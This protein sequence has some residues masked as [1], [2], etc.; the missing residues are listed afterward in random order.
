MSARNERDSPNV[1]RHAEEDRA[2]A[3]ESN[4]RLQLKQSLAAMSY[5]EQVTAIQPTLPPLAMSVP[6][7]VSGQVQMSEAGGSETAHAAGVAGT[8]GTTQAKMSS[9]PVRCPSAVQMA[10][11]T[12]DGATASDVQQ[13]DLGDCYLIAAMGAV[14]H[15]IGGL[16]DEIVTETG[17]TTFSVRLF[18]P[19]TGAETLYAVDIE[20]LPTRFDGTLEFAKSTQAG[21]WWVAVIEHAYVQAFGEGVYANIASGQPG[22]ALSALTGGESKSRETSAAIIGWMIQ[23][24]RKN[25]PM[26]AL[27]REHEFVREA[28][29]Y[30]RHGYTVLE[31]S[32]TSVQLKN[33]HADEGERSDVFTLSK[34]EFIMN[35]GSVVF[36]DP[37][38]KVEEENFDDLFNW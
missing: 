9:V 5:D 37:S 8:G 1:T 33:P 25:H 19:E 35:F 17:E 22:R 26:V 16:I 13:G 4:Q 20:N 11:A 21:E 2:A 18:D 28:G 27:S 10:A 14:A 3:P 36:N 15:E 31:M 7:Q 23:A 34:E 6:R 29:I 38:E 24:K 32:R 12:V 30:P